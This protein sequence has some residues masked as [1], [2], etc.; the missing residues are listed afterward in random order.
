MRRRPVSRPLL[1]LVALY[2]AA[3]GYVHLQQWFDGYRDIP[4][5]VPGS[6]VVRLGFPINAAAA[7]VIVLALVAAAWRQRGGI[8]TVLAAA[9][10]NA[11][12]LGM[13]IATRTGSVFGW[14][15]P[16][17]T[18]GANQTRAVTIGALVLAGIAV[19]TVLL[20]R[21]ATRGRKVGTTT[22]A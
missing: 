4:S 3:N 13:V 21:I 18:P 12:T 9:A 17:W 2:T 11:G 7:A 22:Y 5:S 6:W 16:V 10:L 8:L 15:E 14:S 20:P 1:V 19:L